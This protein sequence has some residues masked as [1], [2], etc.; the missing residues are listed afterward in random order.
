MAN[1]T[2]VTLYGG[3]QDFAYAANLL[4]GWSEHKSVHVEVWQLWADGPLKISDTCWPTTGPLL[5]QQVPLWVTVLPLNTQPP[6]WVWA[7]KTLA[8]IVSSGLQQLIH[9]CVVYWGGGKV[10]FKYSGLEFT[11]IIALASE[12]TMFSNS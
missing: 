8:N 7:N 12:H 11:L 5:T 6:V 2:T 10:L 4:P 1:V 9:S 3:Q